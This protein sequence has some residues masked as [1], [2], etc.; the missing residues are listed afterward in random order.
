MNIKQTLNNLMNKQSILAGIIILVVAAVAV[1]IFITNGAPKNSEPA[2]PDTTALNQ[3]EQ[4]SQTSS[5]DSNPA[6]TA[7]DSAI[8][9]L[10]QPYNNETTIVQSE[11]TDASFVTNDSAII[12]SFSEAYNEN[13]F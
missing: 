6:I 9:N 1:A 5:A 3:S 2:T 7:V 10:L 12:N 8:D 13:S 11:D 4:S